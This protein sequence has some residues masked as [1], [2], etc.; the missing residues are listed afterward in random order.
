MKIWRRIVPT[1]QIMEKKINHDQ[2]HGQTAGRRHRNYQQ[3]LSFLHE[4][5][6]KIC[7]IL[8]TSPVF[9]TDLMDVYHQALESDPTFKAAYSHFLSKSEQLPQAW[10]TLLPQLTLNALTSRNQEIVRAGLINFNQLYSS[11]QLQLNATQAL[12]NYHAWEEVK[13]A[14]ASVKAA[15]AT[16]NDAAQS[17]ILRT[18]TQYT[19]L[20]LA[21]DTLRF[22]EAKKRANKRQFDQATQRFN[23]GLDPITSVYEAEAAYD[24]SVAE[25]ISA[26]HNLSNENQNLSKLTNHLYEHMAELRNNEIPLIRPE[27]NDV[28]E[29]V[30][31]GLK[32]NYNL[33]AAKYNLQASRENIKAK[34]AGNWPIFNLQGITTDTRQSSNASS[35]NSRGPASVNTANA[36]FSNFFI[37]SEQ[38]ISKVAITMNFPIF[39]GGLVA[40]QT[41]QAEYEF[42]TSGQQLEKVYRD[43]IVNS[44][45][46]FNT[47]IDGISKVKADRQ[48]VMSQQNSLNSVSAQYEV[49][50]RTMTDVVLAQEH[51]FEAQEQLAADQY[52]L[53]NAIL[54][55]KYL[56]GT[57]N[58]TDLEEINAWLDTKRIAE[59]AP[60]KNSFSCS[61]KSQKLLRNLPAN[62]QFPPNAQ[63]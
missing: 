56:A 13:Q 20:L 60:G 32:Q 10:A 25:V 14:R 12:F 42:Q 8:F 31:V 38:I 36:L 48:T 22:S 40:S 61:L 39:Q 49:G 43:V 24:Q 52:D 54:N 19:H 16:F 3:K 62:Q 29:W 17:L 26:E 33:Y 50:T 37:P 28:D 59:I 53:I 18:A 6:I 41:R 51:L 46:A 57:L 63:I 5:V 55:L 15:L 23:V 44:N 58:V 30:S 47:I 2:S 21:K 7:F 34:S 27:P 4:V 1:Q 35:T 9:S 45:I 11:N